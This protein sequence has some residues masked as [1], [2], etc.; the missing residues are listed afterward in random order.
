VTSLRQGKFPGTDAKNIWFVEFYAPWCGHCQQMKPA[1][2]KLAKE[3][4]GFVRVGAVNCEQQKGLCAMEG[5]ESYPTL[6][7]KKAGVS[8]SYDGDHSTQAMKE[9]VLDNL[10]MSFANLRKQNQMERYVSGDCAKHGVC[11]MFFNDAHDT[12]VWFKVTSYALRGKIPL[13]E[14]KG[15]NAELALNFD[16]AKQPTLLVMCDGDI[17]KTVAYSGSIDPG[18]KSDAVEKWLD[19]FSAG[20]G[21]AGVKKTPK[22]GLKLDPNANFAKMK[23]GQLKALMHAHSIPCVSCYEKSDFVSAILTFIK[24]SGSGSHDEL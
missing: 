13:A 11:A 23:V 2:E 3:L 4:K 21:C 1:F 18:M 19:T 16:I 15:N 17:E 6:K 20:K 7:L 5:V 24:Q 8:T 14:V 22:Q 12:P 10:P 9:W